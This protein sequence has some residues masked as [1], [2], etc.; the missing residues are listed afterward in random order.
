MAWRG[1]WGIGGASS[2][3]DARRRAR[4]RWLQTVARDEA[5][6]EVGSF[7]GRLLLVGHRCPSAPISSASLMSLPVGPRPR[8][9]RALNST[10]VGG[11][12]S[13]P[14]RSRWHRCTTRSR[15]FAPA[16]ERR[17]RALRGRRLQSRWSASARD[18]ALQ[19]RPD[20]ARSPV[21]RPGRCP[22]SRSARRTHFRWAS[23]VVPSLPS[24]VATAR[25]A[26]HSDGCAGR[27][28]IARR[29]ARSRT[30]EK[31][32]RTSHRPHPPKK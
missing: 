27:Y 17:L 9:Y 16:V 10:Q 18:F 14:N 12:D 2:A 23:A 5:V 6:Q 24:L 30:P 7:R 28:S 25:S 29:M 1:C 20:C 26:A 4:V 8:G 22:V 32:T 15:I 19:R 3:N 11:N 13:T 21:V 31:P